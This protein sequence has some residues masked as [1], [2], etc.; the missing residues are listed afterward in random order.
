MIILKLIAH[1][2]LPVIITM[3]MMI[4]QMMMIPT[5]YHKTMSVRE[6]HRQVKKTGSKKLLRPYLMHYL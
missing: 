5:I 3:V 4:S 6:G 2:P 1:H